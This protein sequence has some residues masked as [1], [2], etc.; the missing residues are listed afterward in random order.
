M[1][2]DFID[3]HNGYLQLTDE[4]YARAKANNQRYVSMRDNCLNMARRE[5][6]T[7]HQRSLC[8]NSNKR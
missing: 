1:V 7:G 6:D 4:E 8:L 3:E 5:K 2:S